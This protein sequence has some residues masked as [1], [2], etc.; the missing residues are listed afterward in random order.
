M[1]EIKFKGKVKYNGSH[2]FQ[3]DIVYGYYYKK[4]NEHFILHTEIDGYDNELFTKEYEVYEDSI[5]QFIGIR[6]KAGN[7]IYE[8]DEVETTTIEGE[9]VPIKG[10]IFYSY[11]EYCIEQDDDSFP[12]CSLQVVDLLNIKLVGEN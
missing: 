3:G 4:G 1:K 11:G 9:I 2:K 12:V 8:K 5:C 6:T 10:R 7:E